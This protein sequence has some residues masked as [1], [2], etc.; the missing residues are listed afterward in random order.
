MFHNIGAADYKCYCMDKEFGGN[1]SLN[2][3]D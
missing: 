2:K 3:V 1:A